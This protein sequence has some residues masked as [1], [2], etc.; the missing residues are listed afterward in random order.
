VTVNC[1]AGL[2]DATGPGLLTVNEPKPWFARSAAV[3][4][5]CNTVVLTTM[6]GRGDAFHN[7]TELDSNPVPVIVIVAG[8]PG[9]TIR[10]EIAVITAAG[11]F[12]SNVAAAEVPP[13]GAG[14]CTAIRLAELPVRS[15]AGRAAFSSVAL[16]NVVVSATPF[17]VI[18]VDG[19]NPEPL[20]S[21]R[22][23]PDP[24]STLA[25][26]I[27]LIAGCGLFTE[28]SAAGDVPPPGDGFT[29]VNFAIVPFARLLAVSVTL[30]FVAELNVVA[31]GAPF[32]CTVE[33]EMNPEPV[34]VTDMSVEPATAEDG[35][36]AVMAGTGFELGAGFAGAVDPPP[37]PVTN[38][39]QDRTEA[40]R[41]H[42]A[43]FI[44]DF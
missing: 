41:T 12:T 24:A 32:H 19:T 23:L 28:K 10:G 44:D 16:T 25:G 29:T 31:I 8:L 17:Q 18:T 11:L 20:T 5:T 36:I 14:F 9:G 21:S 33:L 27:L 38:Q 1:A 37:Q 35:V 2:V 3:R 7:T 30:K 39:M 15:A 4:A 34:I 42:V 22:V 13:P 26:L 43:R 6:V 40:E